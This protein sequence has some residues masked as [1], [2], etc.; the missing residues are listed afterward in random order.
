MV[1]LEWNHWQVVGETSLQGQR[2]F[3]GE[4][5]LLGDRGY[6]IDPMQALTAV[7]DGQTTDR[8]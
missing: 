2:L 1:S 8:R 3:L 6:L 4:D 7:G 5:R